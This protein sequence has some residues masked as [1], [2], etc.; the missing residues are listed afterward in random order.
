VAAFSGS[1]SFVL[2]YLAPAG[3]SSAASPQMTSRPTSGSG[4]ISCWRGCGSRKTVPARRLC[5]WVFRRSPNV[6]FR[7]GV[8]T[9]VDFEAKMVRLH[10]GAQIPYDHL[11][12]ATGSTNNYFGHPRWPATPSG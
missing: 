3:H 2:D 6:R 4:S 8:V 10:D 7:Q 12:L 5:S 11:V 1:H 9:R